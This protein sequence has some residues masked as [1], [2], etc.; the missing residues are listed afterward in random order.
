MEPRNEFSEGFFPQCMMH[1]FLFLERRGAAARSASGLRTG[2]EPASL[3]RMVRPDALPRDERRLV[4]GTTPDYGSK[5]CVAVKPSAG[6]SQVATVAVWYLRA[7][8][9]SSS[10]NLRSRVRREEHV[11]RREASFHPTL[12]SAVEFV[13]SPPLWAGRYTMVAARQLVDRPLGLFGESVSADLEYSSVAGIPTKVDSRVVHWRC[14][15]GEIAYTPVFGALTT[16]RV[17]S[18]HA[19]MSGFRCACVPLARDGRMWGPFVN[20]TPSLSTR[21]I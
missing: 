2:F 7:T 6:K 15:R 19:R 17:R 18:A 4:S 14:L 20:S 3:V 16:L 13:D 21:T 8:H 9:C 1:E 11:L 12:T 10:E 5:K